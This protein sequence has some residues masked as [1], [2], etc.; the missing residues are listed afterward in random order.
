VKKRIKLTDKPDIPGKLI[1]IASHY[2]EYALVWAVNRITGFNFSKIEDLNFKGNIFSVFKY[3]DKK[4]DT[5]LLLANK[6]S[7]A[8]LI[9]KY[10]TIDFFYI[11]RKNESEL[12]TIV[13]EFLK[14]DKINGSFILENDKLLINILTEL[15]SE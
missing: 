5:H 1:G 6:S 15:F 8:I 4:D 12:K 10:K 7:N 2:K 11:S 3:T 13:S 9:P 14:S